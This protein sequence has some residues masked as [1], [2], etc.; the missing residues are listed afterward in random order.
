MIDE[1]GSSND[2][3]GQQEMSDLSVRTEQLV[4]RHQSGDLEEDDD[5]DYRLVQQITNH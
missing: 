5:I 1:S 4:K 3:D 2:T